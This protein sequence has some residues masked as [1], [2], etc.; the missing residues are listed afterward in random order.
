MDR[1]IGNTY[2]RMSFSAISSSMEE[3]SQGWKKVFKKVPFG[4][5]QKSVGDTGTKIYFFVRMR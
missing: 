4:I 1:L 5:C 3:E 2:I